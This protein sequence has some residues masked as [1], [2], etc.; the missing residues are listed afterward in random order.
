MT[1]R[2]T[3]WQPDRWGNEQTCLGLCRRVVIV[4]VGGGTERGTGAVGT[5]TDTA[6]LGQVLFALLLS[7]LN[8]LFLAAASKLLGLECVLRLELGPAMLGDV[9]FRHDC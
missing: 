6:A 2:A 5:G 8:L 1:G 9:S 3:V 4:A 7:D